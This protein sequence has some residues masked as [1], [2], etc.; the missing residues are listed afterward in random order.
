VGDVEEAFRWVAQGPGLPFE[1]EE[2]GVGGQERVEGIV[3]EERLL[4]R[5]DVGDEA[6]QPFL[7]GPLPSDRCLV[8]ELAE[9]AYPTLIILQLSVYR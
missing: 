3:G 5:G 1:V 7:E 2:A 6:A 9:E 4:R 8:W